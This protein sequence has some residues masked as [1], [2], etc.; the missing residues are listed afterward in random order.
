MIAHASKFVPAGS[1]RIA[2][3]ISGNL[4]N[5]AFRTPAGKIVLIVE[6]EGTSQTFNIKYNSKWVSTTL[7]AGAVGT[8]IW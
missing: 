6:N 7:E 5:V 1:V 2:S 8:Y 3:N 4:Q